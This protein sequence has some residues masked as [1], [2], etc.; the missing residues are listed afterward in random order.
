TPYQAGHEFASQRVWYGA[1]DEVK[2]GITESTPLTIRRGQSKN[3]KASFELSTELEAPIAKGTTVGKVFIQLDG[4]DIA[5]YPL[6]TLNEVE[7]GSWF[8]RT[9]DYF[10]QMINGWFS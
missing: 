3:L 9:M 10:K 4:K 5:S 2:L 7:Q 1:T 8:K 6:V